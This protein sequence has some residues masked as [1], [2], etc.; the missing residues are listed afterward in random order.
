MGQ[1]LH[2]RAPHTHYHYRHH[3]YGCCCHQTTIIDIAC[4]IHTPTITSQSNIMIISPS[5]R[6]KQDQLAYTLAVAG[7]PLC[8]TFTY[9]SFYL[10]NGP[11]SSTITVL[12]TYAFNRPKLPFHVRFKI[13]YLFMEKLSL[14]IP[15]TRNS[16]VLYWDRMIPVL[17]VC[18]Y[19]SP[20][21][22]NFKSSK[23]CST[24]CR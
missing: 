12:V 19:P 8:T 5:S 7:H 15:W 22:N 21:V 17:L 9:H 6:N 20:Q 18:W 2:I 1:P 11:P 13:V 16:F 10:C 23:S 14:C 4:D 3:R 24:E